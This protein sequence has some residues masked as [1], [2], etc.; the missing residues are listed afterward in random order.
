LNDLKTNLPQL[1]EDKE[2]LSTAYHQFKENL[3]DANRLFSL[4]YISDDFKN[5]I[6]HT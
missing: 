6:S 3:N 1:L 5:Q 2:G 4:Q